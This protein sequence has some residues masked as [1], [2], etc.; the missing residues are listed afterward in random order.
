MRS[1]P[2]T[3]LLLRAAGYAY[4]HPH[5]MPEQRLYI[6]DHVVPMHTLARC[7]CCFE[8]RTWEKAHPGESSGTGCS[9]LGGSAR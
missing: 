7:P 1:A 5:P 2:Q 4:Q 9:S 8:S 6:A 3:R